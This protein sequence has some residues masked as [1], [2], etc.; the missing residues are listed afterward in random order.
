M[1]KNN[2]SKIFRFTCL[3]CII[4]L[5]LTAI[6]CSGGGG[7]GNGDVVSSHWTADSGIRL[8]PDHAGV[9][10]GTVV[11]DVSVI[12]LSDNTFRAYYHVGGI[13]VLSSVSSDGLNFTLESGTRLADGHGQVRVISLSNGA[14][15]LYYT[16]MIDG[17]AGIGSYYST[18]GLNFTAESGVRIK[19]SD[20][21]VNNLSGISLATMPDGTYR[22][23]F[24]KLATAGG[25]IESFQTF[26]ASSTD[27]LTF[28]KD[29]GIRVGS[30][31]DIDKSAEHP[32]VI[33][34]SDG[35]YR[36]FFYVNDPTASW[37]AVS[38]DGLTWSDAAETGISGVYSVA[39]GNDADVV[40]LADGSWRMYYGDFDDAVGGIIRSTTS[41]QY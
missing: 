12:R 19:A 39:E 15:R 4:G 3:L 18:D 37:T 31:S 35:T 40:E 25:E 21:G 30:G 28:T 14:Y 33:K 7:G 8:D 16:G 23:Y 5:G 2:V 29:D 20:Y 10:A 22:A 1:G 41:S 17:T 36:M 24:S 38:T 6:G 34:K 26:S 11:A 32:F 27:M 13:G 9:A